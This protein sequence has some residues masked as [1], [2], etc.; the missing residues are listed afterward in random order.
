MAEPPVEIDSES[1]SQLMDMGFEEDAVK[2]ALTANK[3]TP[4]ASLALVGWARSSRAI[5]VDS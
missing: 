1:L 5:G 4:V 2:E 3:G